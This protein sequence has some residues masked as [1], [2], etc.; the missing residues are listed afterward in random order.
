MVQD[1][2]PTFIFSPWAYKVTLL[3]WFASP[4]AISVASTNLY[5]QTKVAPINPSSRPEQRNRGRPLHYWPRNS[6]LTSIQSVHPVTQTE[7][8]GH[9]H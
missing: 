2:R 7:K 6:T 4:E 1:C 5:R 9:L 8:W 3:I